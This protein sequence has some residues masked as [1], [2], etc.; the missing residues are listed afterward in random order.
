MLYLLYVAIGEMAMANFTIFIIKNNMYVV[1]Q[2]RRKD[3]GEIFYIG[4]GII[5][6]AYEG[7]WNRRNSDW[8]KVV[9][10]AGGFDVDILETNLT[11][12]ES[13]K[14]ESDYIKKYG[15]KKHKTGIL[16]NERLSG[17]R[18]SSSGYKHT[19]EKIKEISEKTKIAMYEK[20]SGEKLSESL[21]KHFNKSGIKEN[22]SYNVKVAQYDLEGNYIRTFNSMNEAERETGVWSTNISNACRGIYKKSGGFKWSYI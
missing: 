20:N 17:T 4:Q 11:R 7:S 2:H 5:K 19:P 1:Y 12:E 22:L 6:R 3:N 9:E 15:T 8:L 16:V 13:L 10:E 14:V 18:G 21:K